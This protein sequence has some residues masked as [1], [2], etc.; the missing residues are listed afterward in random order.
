MEYIKEAD[1]Q[2][3]TNKYHDTT[4]PFDSF[5]RFIRRDEI[6][7]EE[8]GM[9]G[10]AIKEG[11]LTQDKALTHLS[12]PVRKAM[13]VAYVL[14]HTRISCDNRDVFRPSI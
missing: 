1:Y 6:F 14:K 3:I 9:D 10:E 8:T 11:I 12:H 4:K 2:Y 13:A 5:R 7:A